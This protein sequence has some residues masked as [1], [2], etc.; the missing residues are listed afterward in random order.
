MAIKS[1]DS[2]RLTS[3]PWDWEIVVFSPHLFMPS[4]TESLHD[5]TLAR[6]RCIIGICWL[7]GWRVQLALTVAPRCLLTTAVPLGWRS[8]SQFARWAV[9]ATGTG[10]SRVTPTPHGRAR[11]IDFPLFGLHRCARTLCRPQAGSSCTGRWVHG[12]CQLW[13]YRLARP[14]HFTRG[15]GE[16]AC[17]CPSP[18]AGCDLLPSLCL[19]QPPTPAWA[20]RPSGGSGGQPPTLRGTDPGFGFAS[21][22]VCQA[23][24]RCVSFYCPSINSCRMNE[25]MSGKR[26][27]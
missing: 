4:S 5:F 7:S 18:W 6:T 3:F 21:R 1:Q 23:P 8:Q 16:G 26:S 13:V 19:P 20:R 12:L 15:R 27:F 17:L 2:S 24:P 9:L 22:S 11:T 25:Y 14:S 10:L